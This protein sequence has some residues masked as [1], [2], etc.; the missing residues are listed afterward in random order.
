M[1][2]VGRREAGGDTWSDQRRLSRTASWLRG[3]PALAPGGVVRFTSF[4]EADAWMNRML[5][6]TRARQI[7][8]TSL[9]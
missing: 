2:T 3:T 7:P 9:A 8:R 4:E 6:D 1:R 5:I